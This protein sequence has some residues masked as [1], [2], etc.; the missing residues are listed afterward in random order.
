MNFLT[1]WAAAAI[2]AVVV[3]LLVLLYFLK[4]RRRTES[5]S[6][7]LLWKRA[8]QDLQVNA[9][10]QRLRKNLLLLLQLIILAAAIVALARPVVKTAVAGE[11]SVI[12]LIDRSASM[13]TKEGDRTRLEIAKEQAIRLVKTFNQTGSTWF[14]FGGV[15]DLTR[16]MVVSFADRATIVA[17]FTTNMGELPERIRAITPTDAS[18]HLREALELAEAYMQLTRGDQRPNVGETASRIVL[19]S[20]GQIADARELVLRSGRMEQIRIGETADNVGIT[21][22]RTVRNYERPELVSV[23]VQVRNFS[24]Q[25]VTTDLTLYLGDPPDRL[26]LSDV[27]SVSLK[28][29]RAAPPP[30]DANAPTVEPGKPVPPGLPPPG[31][32]GESASI[33]F[34]LTLEKAAALEVRLARED[35]LLLDNRAFGLAPAPRKLRVLVV[36]KGN[37]FIESVLQGLPLERVIYWTPEQYESK[38]D[39]ELIAGGRCLFDVVILDKHET[40]RLPAGNYLTI[41]CV[42]KIEGV[43]RGD[44][45]GGHAVMWWN[46]T[47]ALLRHVPLEFIVAAKG[48]SVT[49]PQDA[50]TIAEG[51]AGPVLARYSRDGRQYLILTFAIED[52]TWWQQPGLPIFA[53]NALRYLGAG[54]GADQE[55]LRPGAALRIPLPPGADSATLTRPDRETVTLKADATGVARYAATDRVGFYTV[56]PGVEGADRFAINLEDA[57]ESDIAP[58]SVE[59]GGVPV[60]QG[61][62]I[63]TGTPEVWRW[64]VGAAVVVLL[65]EWWIY[66][67][68]VML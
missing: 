64:F 60:T 14:S 12:L 61:E 50:E 36:S 35:A 58:R 34:E 62:L 38:P 5:V 32:A 39:S 9:P 23:F 47:H 27:Q 56:A 55:N 53:Y 49:L 7:T 52:T 15:T 4:L 11:K 54:A 30:E 16:V 48:L 17:P 21:A 43:K 28:P 37:F 67:R 13:N 26:T 44:D 63:K 57:L 51:P 8:V 18:T 42:P 65:V 22:L 33:S 1:P 2:A 31:D 6:S 29:A 40:A 66:N 25:A 46:E 24:P 3:P 59:L 10:F 41:A 68:R 45:L 20:D 19:L